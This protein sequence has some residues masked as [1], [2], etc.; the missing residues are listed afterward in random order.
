MA[1]S[2]LVVFHTYFTKVIIVLAVTS[3]T[4]VVAGAGSRRE[5]RADWTL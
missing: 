2:I 3:L 1:S 5:A 4:A